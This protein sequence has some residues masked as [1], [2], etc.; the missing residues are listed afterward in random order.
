MPCRGIIIHN[1]TNTTTNMKKNTATKKTK[2]TKTKE[3][4]I[5]FMA[6]TWEQICLAYTLLKSR[7]HRYVRFIKEPIGAG[8]YRGWFSV[9]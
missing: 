6:R 8:L 3:R 4:N 7:Y 5:A 9:A 2:T 1:S